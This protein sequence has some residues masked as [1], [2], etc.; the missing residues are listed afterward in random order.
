MRKGLSAIDFSANVC[1]NI[2]TSP[3]LESIYGVCF[4][5]NTNTLEIV[6]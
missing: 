1:Y 4:L 5:K 6:E 3:A 2:P